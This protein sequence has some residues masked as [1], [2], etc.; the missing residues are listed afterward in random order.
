MRVLRKAVPACLQMAFVAAA[1]AIAAVAAP[2]IAAS[3][4]TATKPTTS[5]TAKTLPLPQRITYDLRK[6]AN[7]GVDLAPEKSF[8]DFWK[9]VANKEVDTAY[10]LDTQCHLLAI[11]KDGKEFVVALPADPDLLSHLTTH[12]VSIAGEPRGKIQPVV[13]GFMR[14]LFP[15][16]ML[17]AMTEAYF[18]VNEREPDARWKGD[19]DVT[20]LYSTRGVSQDRLSALLW[21]KPAPKP[22]KRVTLDNVAG[23]DPIMDDLKELLWMMNNTKQ[24]L[25][26]GVSKI[27]T[28]VL[29]VGKPGT[30]KTL[31]AR[32]IAGETNRSFI[33]AAGTQFTDVFMGSGAARVSA[34][35]AKARY[36]AP[37]T[38]FIDEFDALAQRRGTSMARD[39]GTQERE[40]TVNQ[41]LVELDGFQ[42]RSDVV[43]LA[44]T[45]RPS[46]LDPAIVRPGRI[47]K[48]IEI[49]LPDS[50]GREDILKVHARNKTTAPEV[51][52]REVAYRTGG[53]SGADLANLLNEAGFDA[54][55]LGSPSITTTNLLNALDK[56]R[57]M[58]TEDQPQLPVADSVEEQLL[59]QTVTPR[60]KR[61]LAA[62]SAGKALMGCLFDDYED[63]SKIVVAPNNTATGHV[64]FLPQEK[65]Q[66][67]MSS[68]TRRYLEQRMAVAL[69]GRVAEMAIVGPD[70]VTFAAGDLELV[71]NYAREYVMVSGFS[72][73]VGPL[74]LI[75]EKGDRFLSGDFE[76][77]FGEVSPRLMEVADREVRRVVQQ[78]YEVAL[79]GLSRNRHVLEAL[80]DL[81]VEQGTVLGT[82][83]RELMVR[84]GAEKF[85][86]EDN[87]LPFDFQGTSTGAPVAE[88][89][90]VGI[91]GDVDEF[92]QRIRLQRPP[93]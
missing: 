74:V 69:G 31:L 63:L 78:A 62:Y 30:G 70:Q 35:F 41:L 51:D 2:A 36:Y 1:F 56:V 9:A 81:L 53:M 71:S 21:R 50:K 37:C 29:L 54:V 87:I 48:I 89:V 82:E 14:S 19:D 90:P 6:L 84:L 86:E 80:V 7:G 49:P 46:V 3:A 93:S 45:N 79:R 11:M 43:V 28:G 91:G 26:L 22:P 67:V 85:K 83:V 60:E 88:N 16:V 61:I 34:L 32:A 64:V 33:T 20:D 18:R 68:I 58:F 59:V 55:R 44:A 15:V 10:F 4:A 39:A 5:S 23:I 13:F 17:I 73:R 72:P 12:G 24:V 57:G 38:V 75:R 27:P 40:A 65:Y 52:W 25:E 92:L 47:D 76:W 66:N 8:A 77:E 42:D